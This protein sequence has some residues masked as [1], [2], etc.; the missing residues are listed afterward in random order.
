MSAS[1]LESALRLAAHRL[2]HPPPDPETQGHPSA[3]WPIPP[4]SSSTVFPGTPP[5][6]RRPPRRATGPSPGTL[7]SRVGRRGLSRG[8]RRHEGGLRSGQVPRRTIG[9][10]IGARASDPCRLGGGAGAHSRTG[11]REPRTGH[12][13][14]S[15]D[16]PRAASPEE[17]GSVQTHAHVH[18]GRSRPALAFGS[19]SSTHEATPRG[20]CG[21]CS[22]GPQPRASW[23]TS[24]VEPALRHRGYASLLMADALLRGLKRDGGC[25]RPPGTT[26]LDGGR[27]RD[28]SPPLRNAEHLLPRRVG[29]G[30]PAVTTCGHSTSRPTTHDREARS[31]PARGC[32]MTGRGS[33]EGAIVTTK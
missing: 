19:A 9:R 11:R 15:V 28:R 26:G 2:S 12:P 20:R 25:L 16:Q 29:L 33:A 8:R 10:P 17:E 4:A 5:C 13:R 30:P 27:G 22:S 21:S 23:T 1:G 32:W 18:R 31:Y 6:Q 24:G 14:R 7:V 3:T